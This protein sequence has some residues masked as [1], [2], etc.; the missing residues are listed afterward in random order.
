MA[1]LAG[2]LAGVFSRRRVEAAIEATG[3]RAVAA[4]SPDYARLVNTLPDP[5]LVVSGA[6]PEDV[7][8]RRYIFA[9]LAARELLRM[10]QEQ[11][12]LVSAIRDPHVLEAVDEAL[13]GGI[14]AGCVYEIAG[15]QAKVL[16][17]QARPLADATDGVRLAVL[18][19]RDLAI[20]MAA[21]TTS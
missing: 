12:L 1:A 15:A 5:I 4:I 2:A 3:A 17:V 6:D 18:S 9:N 8:G 14:A 11:G 19:F 20:G 13:F 10:D 16:R 21:S 7:S